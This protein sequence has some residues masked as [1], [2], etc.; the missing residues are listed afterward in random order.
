MPVSNPK[1]N[2]NES[3]PSQ[4]IKKLHRKHGK[5]HTLKDYAVDLGANGTSN[6]KAI[7]NAWFH[8]K[9]PELGVKKEPIKKV[10]AAPEPPKK[11][12]SGKK[13]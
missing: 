5:D 11:V 13:R 6:E 3:T 9:R 10:V 1:V 2:M 4:Q 7:V 12:V 8:N